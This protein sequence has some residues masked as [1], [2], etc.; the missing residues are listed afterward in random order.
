MASRALA[1][2]ARGPE[3][4][5]H[6]YGT[7]LDEVDQPVILHWLGTMFDPALAGY[8]GTADIARATR[9]S[10]RLIGEHADKVDGVKVSLLDAEHEIGPAPAYC[11]AGVR[12]YTGDDFNYPE[13]ILGDG[14]HHSDALLGIF[15]AIYPAA[16]TALQALDAGD[17]AR[18][19]ADPRLHPGSG[20]AHLRR[21]DLLL[22]DRHRV[23]VLAERAPARLHHGRRAAERPVAAAPGGDLPARRPGR[24]A[25]RPRTGRRPDV[26]TCCDH[27]WRA[28]MTGPMVPAI[29]TGP[30][31]AEHRHH[32]ELDP[33]ARPS[34]APSGPGS[35]RIGL[36]RD[37]V[38]EVGTERAAATDPRRRAARV[39]PVPRRLPHRGRPGGRPESAGGQPRRHR[40]GGDPGHP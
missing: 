15:A 38:A 35:R 26:A 33:G 21:A 10:R 3:D 27:G 20:P 30:A 31:V 9:R 13:L 8:W 7:L 34:T 5:L 17:P 29:P 6:V 12:L 11:R 32:Q 36:W 37:R 2:V 22:Q 1:T 23:P 14:A 19:R 40:R 24:A 16:S 39:Q 18:A 4:Y 28:S 25:H